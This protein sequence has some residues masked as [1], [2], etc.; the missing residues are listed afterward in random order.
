MSPRWRHMVSLASSTAGILTSHCTVPDR[1]E[2]NGE[3][4]RAAVVREGANTAPAR[5]HSVH[6]GPSPLL[7]KEDTKCAHTHSLSYSHLSVTSD[8]TIRKYVSKCE[9]T[10]QYD[11][12]TRSTLTCSPSLLQHTCTTKS[13]RSS[14]RVHPCLSGRGV[15]VRTVEK[16]VSENP[17]RAVMMERLVLNI[18]VAG[19]G[20]RLAN[21]VGMFFSSCMCCVIRQFG[22]GLSNQS[23]L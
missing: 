12:V 16:D 2:R 21:D 18:C 1:E 11:C 20:A 23:V 10:P 14:T 19:S 7:K 8:E 6:R 9:R 3:H 4:D 17:M 22:N 13:I 15:I 5:T